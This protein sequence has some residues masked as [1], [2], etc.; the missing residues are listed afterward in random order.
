MKPCQKRN[1][2][3][4]LYFIHV[5]LQSRRRRDSR[6]LYFVIQFCCAFG[7]EVKTYPYVICRWPVWPPR[8]R[9]LLLSCGVSSCALITNR[10]NKHR[11]SRYCCHDA[12][13]S[14][15]AIVSLDIRVFYFAQTYSNCCLFAALLPPP[16]FYFNY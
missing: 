12:V 15:S 16:V 1:G 11:G 9:D 4:L 13:L 10:H 6:P 7:V 2:N 14:P 5:L 3:F 8:A